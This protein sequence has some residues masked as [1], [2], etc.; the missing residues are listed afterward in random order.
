MK[1]IFSIL[2]FLLC[3]SNLKAQSPE[4]IPAEHPVYDYLQLQRVAGLLPDYIHETRP[5]SLGKITAHLNTLRKKEHLLWGTSK[6]WLSEFETE[7]HPPDSLR[8]AVFQSSKIRIPHQPNTRKFLAYHQNQNWKVAVEGVGTN[9]T[10]FAQDSVYYLGNSFDIRFRFQGHYKDWLGFYSD[11]YDGF[12]LFGKS[13]ATK[14]IDPYNNHPVYNRVLR[15]DPEIGS[16]YFVQITNPPEGNFDRTSASM[17]VEKGAFFAE[18]ANERLV[19]GSGF[20]E[21]LVAANGGDYFPFFRAGLETNKVQFQFIHADLNGSVGY[22]TNNRSPE[23]HLAI[24]RLL[25]RPNN[26]LSLGFNEMVVYGLRGRE[27]AYMNPFFPFKTAEHAQWDKDNSLFSI[28]STWRPAPKIETNASLLI[29]DLNF[30]KIVNDPKDS[31]MK[32]AFQAGIGTAIRNHILWSAEYTRIE[33]YTYTHRFV[34]DGIEYNS[35]QHNQTSIG[36]PLPPNSDQY[37]MNLK[38]F[39]PNRLRLDTALYYTRRGQNYVDAS[40]NLVNVGGDLNRG[41]DFIFDVDKAF[42]GGN[43]DEGI[44][45]KIGLEWQPIRDI[46]LK[47]YAQFQQWDKQDDVVFLR[48][49]LVVDL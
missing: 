1:Y 8:E 15:Y 2:L 21:P 48:G 9:S 19:L 4:M 5:M 16:L 31:Q 36:H 33:P 42:L 20:S 29:D 10:R 49:S 13:N 25:F 40:G 11:T 46:Y 17:S 7:F 26:R 30:K 18:I 24:H 43:R 23:R 27:L 34:E 6:K 35:Y 14:P 44:G 39:L 37:R 38:W 12:N 28:E 47:G 41:R 22:S 32:W 45:A 3:I